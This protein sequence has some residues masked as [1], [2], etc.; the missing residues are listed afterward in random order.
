ML[1]L[2]L[3]NW[4]LKTKLWTIIMMQYWPERI[5]FQCL[6]EFPNT[7]SYLRDEE[8]SFIKQ[9]EWQLLYG[10][11]HFKILILPELETLIR[12]CIFYPPR[13]LDLC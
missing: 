12:L 10:L 9:I 5:F 1:Q 2:Y 7:D 8:I 11:L 6:A 3:W 13:Q 4:Q